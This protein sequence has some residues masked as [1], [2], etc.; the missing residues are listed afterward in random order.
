ML[1]MGHEVRYPGKKPGDPPITIQV[2]QELE[3]MPGVPTNQREVDWYSREYPLDAVQITDRPAHQWIAA[4]RDTYAELRAIRSEHGKLDRP[5]IVAA[6]TSGELEPTGRPTGED[7][8]GL[9]KVRARELGFIDVGI[10]AYD[11]RYT[12]QSRKNWVKFEHSICLGYD[13]DYELTQTIPSIPAEVAH[14]G[15]YRNAGAAALELGA[16]IRSLGY[17]AQVHGHHDNSAPYIPMFVDAGVG[18]LGACGYLLTPHGGN[19][20]RLMI[21]TTDAKVTYD[22]SVDFGIHAFCQVCQVC[23][24]RCPGR[25]LM[26]DKIWWRGIEKNK[27][28]TKRCRPMMAHYLNCGICMKV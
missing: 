18:Q 22:H 19:R 2:P 28:Y 4:V 10:T 25:A 7:V 26:R 16:Y 27:L 6:R 14:S 21:V 20:Q 23:V 8:S 11:Y 24:N 1:K 3:T 15:A 12:Y 13:Q 9:I 5:L 17:R